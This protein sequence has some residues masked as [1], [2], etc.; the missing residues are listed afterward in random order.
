PL[1]M[2]IETL[3]GVFTK[4][5]EAN[6]TIPTKKTEVFTTASD[7]Q[8][9][10]EIH[11]LQGERPM[12]A[13]NRTIG[14]FNLDGIPPAMRGIPQIEVTF[15]IH[16]NGIL[17]VSAKDKGTGR[18][19]KIRIEA[20]SG[21]SDQE[22]NRM[23]EEAQQHAED[24]RKQREKVDKLNAADSLI[25]QT[26]KQIKEFG[27]KLPADKKTNIEDALTRLKD[28]HRNQDLDAIDKATADL[29]QIFQAAS[30]E[31]YRQGQQAGPQPG[32]D[33][34]KPGG[35]N[36]GGGPKDQEVTDVDFE[37]VK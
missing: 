10:V 36:S 18:E 2:G 6:T 28:A 30:E 24:D 29:N 9:S 32:A 35:G 31:M 17:N 27:D 34:P 25:F 5:I 19:Q 11:V 8:P 16:A 26:E 22:I 14:R 3:G 12:A 33:E 37:E 20:S 15:D 13:Q 23:K 7:N 1:S 4:L 21:L